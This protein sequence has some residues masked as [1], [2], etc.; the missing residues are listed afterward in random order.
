M[1]LIKLLQA[2][3]NVFRGGFMWLYV[4]TPK[5]AIQFL[6]ISNFILII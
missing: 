1:T 4:T 2:N 5:R 6:T 3:K